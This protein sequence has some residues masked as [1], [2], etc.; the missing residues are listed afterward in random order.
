MHVWDRATGERRQVTDHP[1]GVLA[2]AL[3]LDGERVLFWQDE[4][5]SEAGQWYAEPFAGGDAEP[6][7]WVQLAALLSAGSVLR[8]RHD[9]RCRRARRAAACRSDA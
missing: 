2:G 8:A 3:T 9:P 4:T 7:A 1:V 5:G 6:F